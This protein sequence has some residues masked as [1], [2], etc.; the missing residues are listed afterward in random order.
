MGSV[1]HGREIMNDFW[2]EKF[3]FACCQANGNL[4]IN[5]LKIELLGR[6]PTNTLQEKLYS[7]EYK[8]KQENVNVAI[9]Y[10]SS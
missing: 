8:K 3:S 7:F 6:R 2:S 1:V 5:N 4:V 10:T 9:S